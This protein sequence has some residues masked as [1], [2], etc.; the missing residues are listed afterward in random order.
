M[1]K[2][3]LSGLV[4][5]L[6]AAVFGTTFNVTNSGTTFSPATTTISFG[7][8]V[9]FDISTSHNVIE[10]SSATY[11]ANGNTPLD[12]GFSLPFG[13][14][15]VIA[16]K[17]SVGTHYFVCG[18]HAAFGMKGTITVLSTTG[19]ASTPANDGISIYP[20]PS[21]GNFQLKINN[22]KLSKG[23]ELGIYDMLGNRVYA[24]A[25]LQTQNTTQV[26]AAD[27]PKGTYFV[28]LSNGEATVYRKIIVR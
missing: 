5:L 11:A 19:I 17:L 18:P 1:K 3:I 7:D 26:E 20:N 24:K 15:L 8:D 25:D 10:V 13:G 4:L 21:N 22:T 14:G 27:L 23:V 2:I 6:G 28:K 16:E 9:F 12:G